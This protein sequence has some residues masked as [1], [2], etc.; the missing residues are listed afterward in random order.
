MLATSHSAGLPESMTR[1]FSP[2]LFEMMDR[3]GAD[4]R[5][6]MDDLKNLRTINRWCGGLAALRNAVIP[7]SEAKN[8]RTPL[9]FLDLATGSGD[10]PV[11][12]V[13]SFRR[14]G[15]KVHITAVDRNPVML[16]AAREYATGYDEIEFAQEDILHLPYE[17]ARFDI[18]T[19]SLAIHHLS[20][21]DAV[22]I[23]REMDRLSCIGFVINDLSRS[24]VGAA[25]AWIYSRATTHNP[26]TRFD[27][28][29][30][31][32][33]AFKRKELLEIAKEAGTTPIRVYRAPFFRLV[34]VRQK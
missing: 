11:S 9:T 15:K 10:Q 13:R 21:E 7:L 26:M 18:V 33:R 12:L 3:P 14:S 23:M 17:D 29:L 5:V 4:R 25:S 34:A 19:C 28:V 22:R 2:D 30:S 27:S 1:Q 24:H 16:D 20:R 6:L 32:R 8:G 31:I